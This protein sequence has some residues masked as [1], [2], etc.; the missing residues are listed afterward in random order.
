MPGFTLKGKIQLDGS[1]WKSG[2]NQ[3]KNQANR[4]S[5]EV[6]S[7][8]KGRLA[9]AFGVF[10]LIRGTSASFAR[11]GEVRDRSRMLGMDPEMYQQVDFAAAQSGASIDD[12]SKAIKRLAEAQI[13]ARRGSKGLVEAFGRY[14]LTVE[15]LKKLK[16]DELFFLLSE[17][18]EK[19]VNKVNQLGDMQKL[20]GRSGGSLIPAFELGFG[21]VAQ[22][23]KDS[24]VVISREDIMTLAAAGD[25]L[26]TAGRVLGKEGAGIIAPIAESVNTEQGR[27]LVKDAFQSL[28]FLAKEDLRTAK[29]VRKALNDIV[30]LMKGLL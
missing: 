2:L 3:A 9:A 12:A 16:P 10:G 26:L 17:Q 11:A 20:L 1:Q 23:A 7:L 8:I 13:D 6:S 28:K 18:V 4:W 15:H 5:S 21:R 25:Q 14:G 29:D 19:G 30:G 22:E 27:G 24:G